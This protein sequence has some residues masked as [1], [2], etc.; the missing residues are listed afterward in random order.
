MNRVSGLNQSIDSARASGEMNQATSM[1]TARAAA[2]SAVY[3]CSLHFKAS[4]GR[5]IRSVPSVPLITNV[6]SP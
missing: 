6:R 2:V 4:G 5:P 1:M 3:F